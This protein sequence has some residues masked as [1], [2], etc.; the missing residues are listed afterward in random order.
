[1]TAEQLDEIKQ[2]A[3][4]RLRVGDVLAA[5]CLL[6]H[7]ELKAALAENER[8]REAAKQS[9]TMDQITETM[10]KAIG[11]CTGYSPPMPRLQRTR[12]KRPPICP[13][14]R[15]SAVYI[16]AAASDSLLP[17]LR[18]MECLKCEHK[19]TGFFESD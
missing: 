8:L 14:C 10:L 6:L 5:H 9:F 1:M 19:W 18:S 4:T 2:L 7:A 15:C 17:E 3:E 16:A 13:M 11:V 12:R